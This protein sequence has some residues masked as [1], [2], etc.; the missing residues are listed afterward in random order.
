MMQADYV[1]LLA[2][3]IK[4][5][6]N[7]RWV[8]TDLLEEDSVHGAPGGA[9]RVQATAI[10]LG[11]FPDA[12]VITGGAKGFDVRNEATS[13]RPLLAEILH[14][15][16]LEYGIPEERIILERSSN[17]TYQE[18][19]ELERFANEKKIK[20][21]AILTSRWHIPRLQAMIR[22]K[23]H[24]LAD[25]VALELISAEDV[26]IAHDEKKWRAF[27]DDA[28]ESEWM[29]QRTEMETRGIKEIHDGTYKFQ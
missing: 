21:L 10:L 15:E 25:R 4:Q 16:L 26:L 12:K 11:E 18:L 29:K 1:A 17:N 28:Y 27:I 23:F 9:L 13:D 14:D 20:K 24:K 2:S 22:V 6:V 19:Q 3:G 5:D 8:S 7:G